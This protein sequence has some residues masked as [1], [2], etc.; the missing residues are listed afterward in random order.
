MSLEAPLRVPVELRGGSR[1]FRLAT[2][3]WPGGLQLAQVVPEE[4]EGA[5]EVRFPLPGNPDPITCRARAENEGRL[6]IFIGLGTSE[7]ERIEA[8]LKERL[9]LSA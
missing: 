1:W 4:L 3:L 6:L 7:R 2:L 8:Y 5:F 9:G